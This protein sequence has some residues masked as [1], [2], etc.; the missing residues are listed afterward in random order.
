MTA[1]KPFANLDRLS[2]LVTP[3]PQP[4][5]YK[6]EQGSS[7]VRLDF[8]QS[9]SL[10][11]RLKQTSLKT[12]NH[13]AQYVL[14]DQNVGYIKIKGTSVIEGKS[15]VQINSSVESVDQGSIILP[16][17]NVDINQGSVDL[18]VR[19]VDSLLRQGTAISEGIYASYTTVQN[20]SSLLQSTTRQGTLTTNQT[21]FSLTQVED[22]KQSLNQGS[23][24]INKILA[25][26]NQGSRK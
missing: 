7:K 18:R 21:T 26:P 17:Y 16:P 25:T 22:P 20:P 9:I 8:A 3:T 24:V 19:V 1:N 5:D 6:P 14:S 4:F 2:K 10:E 12:T 15:T 13:L 11:D 23:V